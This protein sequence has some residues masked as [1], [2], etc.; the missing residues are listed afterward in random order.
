MYTYNMYM[1]SI[2]YLFVKNDTN[3]A[4]QECEMQFNTK[5]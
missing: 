1:Y 2:I 3:Y 4:G 5:R